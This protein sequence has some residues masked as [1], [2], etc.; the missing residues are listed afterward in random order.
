ML[1][2]IIT[3]LVWIIDKFTSNPLQPTTLDFFITNII[4]FFVITGVILFGNA[5]QYGKAGQV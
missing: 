2:S 3:F 5:V 1:Y 4:I